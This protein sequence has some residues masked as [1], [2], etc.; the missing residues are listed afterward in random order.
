MLTLGVVAGSLATGMPRVLIP[1]GVVAVAALAQ[2][3]LHRSILDYVLFS[4]GAAVALFWFLARTRLKKPHSFSPED[5]SSAAWP[6][7][8]SFC[9]ACSCA[10]PARLRAHGHPLWT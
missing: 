7:L 6:L 5:L 8:S 1:A 3:H 10:V 2:F 9:R 4:L